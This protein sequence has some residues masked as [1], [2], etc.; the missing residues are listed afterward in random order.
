MKKLFLLLLILTLHSA[1][2]FS[3]NYGWI[4]PNKAYLKLFVAEDGMYRIDKTDFTNAG[5]NANSIDPRTVKVYNKG[6]QLPIYFSGEQDGNFGASDYLDFYGNRNYGGVINTYDQNNTLAYTTNEF[7]NPYSDTN[8]YW[9][10]WGGANGIRFTNSTYSV[11]VFYPNSFFNEVLHFEKDN[12]YTQGEVLNGNDLRFLST[13]KFR[14]EGWYW[15]TLY[16]NQ[17]LSDTFSLPFLNTSPQTA[18]VRLFAYPTNRSTSIFNEHNLEIRVNGNLVNTIISNDMNRIDTNVTF[19]STL[20]SNSSVNTVS[21]KYVPASGYS[22]SMYLDMFEVQYPRNFKL[23][24]P[25]L[26]SNLPGSDTTSKLFRVNGAV[27]SNP[28]NIYDVNNNIRITNAAFNLD[29]L[30]FTGKSNG[31]FEMINSNITKK[32]F[33]I[34]QK[35]VPDL[36]SISNGADYLVIYHSLFNSQAEQLRSYRQTKDD[37]RSVKAE[38]EDIYD[39]FNYGLE[40]P[41][42]VRNFTTYIYNNWQLPKLSFICL[43]GRASLDPKKNLTTSSYYQNLVPTYGLPPSD[44]YFANFNIGTFCYYNQIAIGRLPAYYTSEA[45]T[46]VDKIIAYESQSPADWSKDFVF[47]TGG[48]TLSEQLSHQ[49]KSNFEISAYINPPSISG[50]AHKI[51]RSDTSGS[52]TF[53][54]RDSIK[55]DISRGCLFVNFRGHAGSHDWEVGMED[56]NT[57]SNGSKLPLVLSLTCFTGENSK[58]DY[59]GF[60]ERFIYLSDKGAIGFVGTTGWSYSGTGNDYGSHFLQTMKS[61]T[62]RRI[63]KLS[64]YAQTQMSRDSLSFSVRHTLN[65]YSLI[66]D[67]AVTL[68]FPVRPELSITNSDYKLSNSFPDIGDNLSLMIYPKNFGTHC[69]S[70]K[71][72]FQLKKNSQ[73][74]YSKDTVLK[75]LKFADSTSFNFKIDSAGIYSAVVT[76]DYSNWVPLENKNN[77]SITISIPVKNTSF[78]PLKPVS[79]SVIS[80]DSVEFYA[81]NPRVDPLVYNVQ[82]LLQFDTTTLFNSPLKRTFINNNISGVVT[83]FKTSVPL[84]VNNKLYFW[85]TN[86]ILNNDSSGWSGV[87]TFI[88]NNTITSSPESQKQDI[89]DKLAGGDITLLKNDSRQFSSSDYSNTNFGTNGIELSKFNANLFVRSLGSNAEESSYFS[90]GGK[91]IYIDAGLNTGLNML[92]VRKVD[93]SIISLKNLKMNSGAPSSDSLVTYLNTF[94]STHYLMLLNAAYVQA[95]FLNATAKAKLRQFGSIYCDSIGLIGYFHTWSLIGFLGAN[96]SQVSE[97]FDPCCRPA[98]YCTAC[99]HWS[100]SISSMDV[101]LSRTSGTVSNIVGPAEAWTDFSWTQTLNPSSSIKFDV[102]GIDANNQQT[103]LLSDLQTNAFCNL[104]SINAFQYPRLNLMA[105]IKI[106]TVSGKVSSLLNSIKAHYVAPAE[107]TWDISSLRIT[108]SFKV[109]E[110]LKFNFDNHNRGYSNFSGFVL[111]VYKKSISSPNLILTDTSSY[112]IKPDS[113]WTYKNKF[114]IPYFRDS[115]KIIV[116]VLPKSQNNEFYSYNNNVEFSMNSAHIFNTPVIQV[117]SDNHP[118]SNGDYVTPHP[119]IKVSVSNAVTAASFISDTTRLAITLNDKYV[120]YFVNGKL[121][122]LFKVMEK[123][124]STSGE[125]SVFYYPEMQKGSNK[126]SV[127]FTDDNNSDTVSFDVIVSDELAIKD[128]YN[129]P[130]PMKEGTSFI[131]NLAGSYVP[132]KFKI[133]IYTVSGRLIKQIESAVN[134]GNNQIPWDGRDDDGDIIANG[135]YLYKLVTEDESQTVTQTQKLV[136]LR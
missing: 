135:T 104:S 100:E 93:G 123:D 17:T 126:L 80:T 69:D 79:N 39:I 26:S 118:L 68:N 119:E 88:Y 70:T 102:Y 107:I 56:P 90:V 55:N 122:T 121:N 81:L 84:T 134:I 111:N 66:G 45:Q 61:D 20:L 98:P 31:K 1:N 40:S 78:V 71:I 16:D 2:S 42:A 18:S 6:E 3:Q 64:K 97:M 133:K 4:T 28:I 96:H 52:T 19:S 109:G 75:N 51:Y 130:N 50:D 24:S 74:Y 23:N 15:A 105:K 60:G 36:V 10:E 103:L 77:N 76:L 9:I 44:G 87:Q 38:I 131:F 49:T 29:T 67:P 95:G 128:L 58:A 21:I 94:D 113:N 53:N 13:E 85:R 124:N 106:D 101:T 108:S 116:E 110:D 5:V 65:C 73:N 46:M 132:S 27:S 7:Y 89:P 91:N 117:F 54:F 125:N 8:V 25:K 86:C 62:T 48:G 112:I 32:P 115:M 120:P 127:V 35:Q 114:K 83:K 30:K 22:G 41:V 43:L 99:D 34:K 59:R 12:F 11:S 72:R 57:L 136:M 37:F 92:K 63:G 82:V 129:Y 33:R 14:G 47:I